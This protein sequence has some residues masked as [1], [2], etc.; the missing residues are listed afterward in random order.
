MNKVQFLITVIFGTL[1]M[2]VSAQLWVHAQPKEAKTIQPLRARAHAWF[3]SNELKERRTQM[4]QMTRAL[5][6]PCKYCHTSGFKGYTDKHKVSLEMMALSAEHSIRCD[7]CHAGKEKLTDIGH[8]AHEMM[9]LS[10]EMG[11]TC[12]HCHIPASKFK[13]L[14]PS[15]LDYQKTFETPERVAPPLNL[16]PKNS[17]NSKSE[18][19]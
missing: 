19:P 1:L 15:G 8:K 14:T 5:R 11:V 13:S 17:L 3:E 9:R 16:T 2:S 7:D 12:E 4:R 10:K 6:Q 18:Q